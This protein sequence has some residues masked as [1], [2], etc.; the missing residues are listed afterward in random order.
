MDMNRKPV[1]MAKIVCEGENISWPRTVDLYIKDGWEIEYINLI[2]YEDSQN[3][4]KLTDEELFK[5]TLNIKLSSNDSNE[6]VRIK[7]LEAII[8]CKDEEIKTLK[9]KITNQNLTLDEKDKEI[10]RLEQVITTNNLSEKFKK[11]EILVLR[12]Y[13]EKSNCKIE[14]LKKDKDDMATNFSKTVLSLAS[15]KLEL[16][17]KIQTLEKG[18]IFLHGKWMDIYELNDIIESKDKEIN[19]LKDIMDILEY[20]KIVQLEERIAMLEDNQS[21]IIIELRRDIYNLNCILNEKKC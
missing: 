3:K 15:E 7:T 14:E 5:K 19:K 17:E 21:K 18:E 4:Q 9:E 13:L 16:E 12:E 1:N 8:R 6:I 20:K 2:L 10:K 11:R